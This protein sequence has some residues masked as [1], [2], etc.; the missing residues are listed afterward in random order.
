M[1]LVHLARVFVA[2]ALLSLMVG[3]R[4][5]EEE[6]EAA[7]QAQDPHSR[8]RYRIRDIT[9]IITSR[10]KN[11]LAKPPKD[12]AEASV[13]NRPK[14]GVNDSPGRFEDDMRVF[15]ASTQAEDADAVLEN[16]PAHGGSDCHS[17]GE[18]CD[19]Q[20]SSTSDDS[21]APGAVLSEAEE[22]STSTSDDDADRPGAAPEADESTSSSDDDQPGVEVS[23]TSFK[24]VSR[25]DRDFFPSDDA[26]YPNTPLYDAEES[27]TSDNYADTTTSSEDDYEASLTPEHLMLD[28]HV[29]AG[30]LPAMSVP[31]EYVDGN[32]VADEME[33]NS[34]CSSLEGSAPCDD[35]GDCSA[36]SDDNSDFDMED[37]SYDDDGDDDIVDVDDY[38]D[39][40]SD[41]DDDTDD[42]DKDS[43]DN[44]EDIL[45]EG[46]G[47]ADHRS[48]AN[49]TDDAKDLH[50]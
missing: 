37:D 3:G 5:E 43:D 16:T 38:D 21:D 1:R 32:V 4:T 11:F 35:V 50:E 36:D 10:L 41:S 25:D 24:T 23:N 12:N 9:N 44:I 26:V 48:T 42:S 45:S 31:V 40:E 20:E 14:K 6:E 13:T 30:A 27:S 8:A 18:F 34:V 46:D 22:S 28:D 49:G 15:P 17:K 33:D 29:S 19:A 2:V 47:D 7:E 39:M